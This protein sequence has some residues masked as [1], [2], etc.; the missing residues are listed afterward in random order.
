MDLKRYANEQV[1][2]AV[3]VVEG[4]FLQTRCRQAEDAVS[5][6]SVGRG[7]EWSPLACKEVYGKAVKM[8]LELECGSCVFDLTAAARL[9]RAGIFAAVEGIYGGAYRQKF[10]FADRCEPELTCYASGGGWTDGE[11]QAAAELA[12]SILQARNLV[13]RPANL[14]TP[15]LFARALTA[16]AE[17][18]PIQTR[19]YDR[20]ELE[21]L[22]LSAL[23]SVGTSSGNDPCLVALRYTGDPES[24]ERLGYVGKGVTCDSGGY[25][26]KPAASMGGI[27]GDMAG[28]AAVAGA[29]RALAANGVRVNVTAVIPACENRISN[30]S[31]L[32]GDVV[33]SLSGKTIEVLN[34]DAEGRLILCDA[35]TWAIR[36]EKVTRLADVA[37]LTGAIYAMLGHVAAGVMANDDSW[38]GRLE[39]AAARS[40]ERYWRMPAFPEYEKLIESE[41][42]DVRNTSK[43]GCGAITAGLFLGRFVEGLPWL[44][45][46]IA[47][48]A[49]G[50]SPV[51]QHQVPGATGAAV[52]TLYHLAA[53]MEEA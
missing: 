2:A 35:I 45:L 3:R 11:L 53:G 43:D 49:D 13:N 29:V 22:G 27:K 51:W 6:I 17:G 34:T 14:L 7:E 46:D 44:H 32:P 28:G 52:S 8:A 39:K 23:L 24:P 16:M 41:L 19:V 18:L 21:K 31:T 47:G 40:G 12:R 37:T 50:S 30:A 10:T 1:Q 36:E 26:L 4:P 42:A 25:C 38:Y 48:T 5:E 15:A 20:A 33:A 9:G